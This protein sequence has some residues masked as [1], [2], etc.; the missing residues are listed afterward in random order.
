M[1][2]DGGVA[3]G[4]GGVAAGEGGV[5]APPGGD[6]FLGVKTTTFIF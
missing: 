1:A 2:G 3:A 6:C 4:E 5:A